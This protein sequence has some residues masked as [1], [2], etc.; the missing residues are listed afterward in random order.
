MSMWM[1]VALAALIWGG[2][3]VGVA[4]IFGA[5]VAQR[6]RNELIPIPVGERRLSATHR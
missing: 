3:S 1:F 6:D 2:A 5:V 4:L